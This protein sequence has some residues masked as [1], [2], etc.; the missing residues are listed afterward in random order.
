MKLPVRK[1]H[2]LAF[3]PL[4]FLT[5]VFVITGC[6]KEQA[7]PSKDISLTYQDL[8]N[9]KQFYELFHS[10][11]YDEKS[12]D[13]SQDD[14]IYYGF[15]AYY[16]FIETGETDYLIKIRNALERFRLLYGE[17]SEDSLIFEVYKVLALTYYYLGQYE[18]TSINAERAYSLEIDNRKD[19]QIILGLSYY[20]SEN[21]KESFQEFSEINNSSFSTNVLLYA[22]SEKLDMTN[23]LIDYL[24]AASDTSENELE[25]YIS[26]MLLVNHYT[27]SD[28]YTAA[29][30]VLD[31]LQ[32]MISSP[33]LKSSLYYHL[34]L[35]YAQ[36][37]D[38]IKA[39]TM[40]NRSLEFYTN[41]TFTLDKLSK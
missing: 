38:Y 32:T 27:N 11:D 7:I 16:L 23:Q 4:L 5:I 41:N 33:Y 12:I 36:Q 19:I 28:Q 24:N 31:T 9:T 3:F 15:S 8:W 20:L 14:L 21:Y 30:D 13:I 22:L 18:N 25:Q 39:R 26:K 2:K 37:G 29:L 17:D 40:W 35:S 1:L 34:G 6:V 10:I